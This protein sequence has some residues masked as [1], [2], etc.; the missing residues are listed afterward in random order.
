MKRHI[1]YIRLYI[2]MILVYGS[3][4][5]GMNV[6][7]VVT[8]L[9][10]FIL[11]HISLLSVTGSRACA[12][13]QQVSRHLTGTLLERRRRFCCRRKEGDNWMCLFIHPGNTK[14]QMKTK[15]LR[16][17]L[18]EERRSM[19]RQSPVF[20]TLQT[21]TRRER[22]ATAQIASEGGDLSPSI[23]RRRD[24]FTRTG[25]R[26]RKNEEASKHRSCRIASEIDRKRREKKTC[27][28]DRRGHPRKERERRESKQHEG[29]EGK[30]EKR[31]T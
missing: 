28:D 12:R 29:S 24:D 17:S 18:E 22:E 9:V 27:L 21:E 1:I 31:E 10:L 25:R 6:D 2:Y 23:H 5:Y 26:T 4:S 15:P 20:A 16:S 11:H 7:R 13:S 30:A 19:N 14:I 3:C 8:L